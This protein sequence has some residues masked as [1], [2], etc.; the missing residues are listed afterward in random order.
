MHCNFC[1]LL[2]TLVTHSTTL[3][4]DSCVWPLETNHLAI[5]V[6]CQSLSQNNTSSKVGNGVQFIPMWS[7]Y[8]SPRP[9]LLGYSTST[10]RNNLSRGKGAGFLYPRFP[11]VLRLLSSIA[12]FP[13]SQKW[14][15]N[16][17]TKWGG[18]LKSRP[19]MR[20]WDT[21]LEDES[22]FS[23]F[24]SRMANL[25]RIM[26]PSAEAKSTIWFLSRFYSLLLSPF[27]AVWGYI[28]SEKLMVSR[29]HNL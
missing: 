26:N 6:N 25:K 19:E 5:Q 12:G 21:F 4:A 20:T 8:S 27:L 3:R 7:T 24:I 23:C 15:G 14:K 2:A 18:Q 10:V 1:W 17:K 29:L 16:S 22:S 11:S 13:I 9:L 28:S